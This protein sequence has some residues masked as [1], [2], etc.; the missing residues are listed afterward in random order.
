MRPPT[1]VRS[2][3]EDIHSKRLNAKQYWLS[4]VLVIAVLFPPSY[5]GSGYLGIKLRINR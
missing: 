4:V 5:L 3:C 2:E 1:F